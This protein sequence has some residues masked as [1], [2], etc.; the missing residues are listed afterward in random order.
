M[1]GQEANFLPRFLGVHR[2]HP[3][4]TASIGAFSVAVN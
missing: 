3:I 2:S 4:T 1:S